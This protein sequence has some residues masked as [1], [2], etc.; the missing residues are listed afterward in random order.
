[1]QRTHSPSITPL[2]TDGPL[3]QSTLSP[4]PAQITI[5]EVAR[6][7]SPNGETD[8]QLALL[9]PA[10]A[11]HHEMQ[12]WGLHTSGGMT[13]EVCS[14]SVAEVWVC[15]AC[16]MAVHP[17]CLDAVVIEGYAFCRRCKSWAMEQHSLH[18]TELQKQRWRNRLASQLTTWREVTITTTG[19]LG[20]VGM[21]L[22][23]AGAMIAGGTTALVRGA[24]AGAQASARAA[25]PP[26]PLED[27][28]AEGLAGGSVPV[29][30]P[31]QPEQQQ[32][33]ALAA[34]LTDSV[35]SGDPALGDSRP[36][37]SLSIVAM[38]SDLEAQTHHGE[39]SWVRCRKQ[40]GG[41]GP[42]LASP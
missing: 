14:G 36:D 31:P 22:G 12:A 15:S 16:Y 18:T 33:S 21:A 11:H 41:F 13:C 17:Q 30:S 32:P 9:P 38:G 24:I 6:V 8:H 42:P 10:P 26:A 5:H 20:T 40:Q 29:P 27:G 35:R 7:M 4:N 34:S 28:Q 19:A 2:L 23:S 25:S 37:T 39:S 1:M 3:P